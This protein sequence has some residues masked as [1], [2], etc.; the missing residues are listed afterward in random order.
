MENK[1]HHQ[2][3]IEQFSKQAKGYTSIRSHSQA[4]EKL[5]S[6]ASL[7]REKE[8]LDIACGSGIVSCEFAK[9]SRHVTGIDLTEAML[10]EAK[11]RQAELGIE[12][13]SWQVGD[14]AF[15]PFED[16]CFSIV[17]SRFG[18]HHFVDPLQILQEMKRVCQR[19]GKVMVV[20]VSVPESKLNKYNEMERIRD[21]SHVAALSI[22]EFSA[23]FEQAGFKSME[24]DSYTMKIGLEEQLKA[25]FPTDAE[26]L[27]KMITADVGKNELGVEVTRE[28]EEYYL[29]Y[30]ILI[31]SAVK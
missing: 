25:S 27:K 13:V 17:V 8:V 6:S 9:Y 24:T 15:L 12:N 1:N 2:N 26:A 28:E 5:V 23:L 22:A 31:L 10:E 18:F 29:H 16:E 14:V 30:P 20:D 19:G 3:I 11:K 7:S 21:H 4:L